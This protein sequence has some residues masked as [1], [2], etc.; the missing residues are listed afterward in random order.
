M[1]VLEL[2]GVQ[3][4]L[5]LVTPEIEIRLPEPKR[6][7]PLRKMEH[8]WITWRTGARPSSSPRTCS[9]CQQRRP[10][11]QGPRRNALSGMT[12]PPQRAIRTRLGCYHLPGTR[13]LR[14]SRTTSGEG[15]SD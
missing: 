8:P 11:V 13:S 9:P 14:S 7:V 2:L 10:I 6:D 4:D 15:C 1:T 3:D 5:E 12:D